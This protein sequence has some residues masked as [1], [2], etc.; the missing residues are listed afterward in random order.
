VQEGGGLREAGGGGALL[1]IRENEAELGGK[2]SDASVI[3]SRSTDNPGTSP[4][5][6][7]VARS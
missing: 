6:A 4:C 5:G 7:D 2:R 3:R 1:R